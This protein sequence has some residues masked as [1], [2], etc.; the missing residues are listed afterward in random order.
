[1]AVEELLQGDL[2]TSPGGWEGRKELTRFGTWRRRSHNL[3][4]DQQAAED[5]RFCSWSFEK[6]FEDKESFFSSDEMFYVSIGWNYILLNV[7]DN[8]GL[9]KWAKIERK[10]GKLLCVKTSP[11][12]WRV[13]TWERWV[14][15]KILQNRMGFSYISSWSCQVWLLAPPFF[16]NVSTSSV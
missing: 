8:F 2:G 16:P 15:K 10:D 3:Q 1:M 4:S 6:I 14:S 5:L 11:V 13:Y 12:D 9:G 7:T